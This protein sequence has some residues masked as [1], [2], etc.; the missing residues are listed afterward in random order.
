[1]FP[2]CSFHRPLH[3]L[4]ISTWTTCRPSVKKETNISSVSIYKISSHFFPLFVA[5]F[6]R[7]V[8]KRK[9][10]LSVH[11]VASLLLFWI[12]THISCSVNCKTLSHF[13]LLP[14]EPN[15]A[16]HLFPRFLHIVL[17]W[18][19]CL[20]LNMFFLPQWSDAWVW[21]SPGHRW[22]SWRRDPKGWWDSSTWMSIALA[23]A[24]SP[25]ERV[26]RLRVSI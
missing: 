5:F 2:I 19:E 9:A 6:R 17:H 3:D 18:S 26:R 7:S 4:K 24:G 10:G 15:K 21:C 22:W 1:M 23:F 20:N 25:H 11:T 8:F 13:A 16:R 14:A 12:Q